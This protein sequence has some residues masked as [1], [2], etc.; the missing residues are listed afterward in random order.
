MG[1]ALQQQIVVDNRPG[2]AGVIGAEVAAY[3]KRE[4]ARWSTVAKA[5]GMRAG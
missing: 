3:V 5:T 2:G 4:I 1:V